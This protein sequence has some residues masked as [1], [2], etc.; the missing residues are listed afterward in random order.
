MADVKHAVQ[1]LKE[2]FAKWSFP[3]QF[4]KEFETMECLSADQGMETFLVR[5]KEN[6]VL[7]IARCYD[8]N[9]YQ[10]S[11]EADI[12]K[13][14]SHKGLP[15]FET[16]YENVHMICFLRNYIEGTP[17]DEYVQENQPGREEVTAISLQICDILKYLHG[18]NPPIIHRDIKPR[19]I[20]IKKDKSPVL[21]DFDIARTFKTESDEDTTFKGT[22]IYA[23]PEQY[24]FLQTD[25]RSDIY[26][27][28]VTLRYM[29]TGNARENPNIQLYP[30]LAAIIR[31]CTAFS[32]KERFQDVEEVKKA[33]QRAN[34]RSRRIQAMKRT[35]A[36][37]FV[38]CLFSL[39]AWKAYQYYT[40]DPFADGHIPS[41]LQDEERMADACQYLEEKYGT[42]LF[43]HVTDYATFGLMKQS[44]E[45]MYGMEHDYAWIGNDVEPPEESDEHFFP[46]QIGDEQYPDRL[47]VCYFVTKVYWPEKV[48][49]WS[50]LKDDNGQY[51]GARIAYDWC[52]KM[53]ILTGVNRP[54]DSSVGEVAIALA[55]ADRVFEALKEKENQ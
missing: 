33:L 52:E 28:G 36:A 27:F 17:L 1:E 49:D 55:N 53:G 14:L 51:P 20:I 32:P 5:K 15:A 35:A 31:K 24:G 16:E 43:D 13:K 26:S 38:L 7:Y 22:R 11:I 10:T 45:E 8:R 4:S 54:D 21:I 23:P 19:N 48:G 12:L 42:H 6:D 25:S 3:E 46:W 2:T 39:V 34:P 29:L 47:E 40:F 44:L 30:P 9:I 37:L 50:S 41:V 18:Q